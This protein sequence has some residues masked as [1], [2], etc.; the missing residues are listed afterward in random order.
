MTRRARHTSGPNRGTKLAVIDQKELHRSIV[1]GVASALES[2]V[3]VALLDGHSAYIDLERFV[4]INNQKARLDHLIREQEDAQSLAKKARAFAVREEDPD[5]VEA[6]REDAR[7]HANRARRI[8]HSI[9]AMRDKEIATEVPDEFTAETDYLIYAIASLLTDDGR[10]PAEARSALRTVLHSFDLAQE[11]SM[12]RWRM[13]LLV[14]ADG[15]VMILGPITGTVPVRG[16][17][18]APA[19]LAAVGAPHLSSKTRSRRIHDLEKAGYP[20]DLAT[21]ACLAPAPQLVEALLGYDPEWPNNDSEFNHRAF[22]EHLRNEWGSHPVWAKGVYIQTAWVRQAIADLVANQG[23]SAPIAD[24][25]AGLRALGL[26]SDTIHR[27]SQ[28]GP[29]KDPR[30]PPWPPTVVRIDDPSSGSNYG[31][32]IFANPTCPVCDKPATAVVRVI[33]VPDAILCRDC[34]VMPSRPDLVFPR[35]YAGLALPCVEIPR[36][37]TAR[38]DV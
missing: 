22:N 7:H 23:G 16:R 14:P 8:A 6:Y 5:L 27:Y 17:Q 21:T 4:T 36:M 32:A 30:T 38:H 24:L 13:E 1:E 28:P 19:E 34:L 25:R 3:R 15:K 18:L 26:R 10:L 2:G 35:I 9:S 11:G 29:A 31:A 33:E 37:Q 12:I 20:R